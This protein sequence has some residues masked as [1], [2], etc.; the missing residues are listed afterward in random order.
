MAEKRQLN[1]EE[2]KTRDYLIK[3]KNTLKARFELLGLAIEWIV[4]LRDLDI[5]VMNKFIHPTQREFRFLESDRNVT[6]NSHNTELICSDFNANIIVNNT[7]LQTILNTR[8]HIFPSYEPNDYPGLKIKYYWDDS[9]TQE[10]RLVGKCPHKVSCITLKGKKSLCVKIT[11][12]VFQSGRIIVT[13]GKSVQQISDAYS[14]I[15]KVFQDN[16]V[17]IKRGA[18]AK[19]VESLNKLYDNPSNEI[20]KMM[21]K[22]K[23]YYIK[24]SCIINNTPLTNLHQY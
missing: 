2:I 21:K 17:N 22:K 7:K 13:A 20:R 11:I 9:Q 19:A 6:Y 23:L 10:Q 16:Y 1:D 14:F 3:E 8:Y 5:N 4:E 24:K 18:T 15:T 12:S